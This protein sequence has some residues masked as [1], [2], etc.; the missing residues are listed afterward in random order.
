MA[1]REKR[2]GRESVMWLFD[3]TEFFI[4]SCFVQLCIFRPILI[5][6]SSMSVL[7]SGV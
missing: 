4:V 2:F 1:L 5:D 6:V 3:F 7:H